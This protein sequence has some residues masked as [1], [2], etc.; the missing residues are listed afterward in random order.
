LETKANKL[1]RCAAPES[2]QIERYSAA[3][4]NRVESAIAR[5]CKA[6]GGVVEGKVCVVDKGGGK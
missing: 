4:I 6:I 5:E 3:V 2:W 1:D